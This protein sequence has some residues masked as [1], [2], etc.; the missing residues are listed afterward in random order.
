M[1]R[2]VTK[3]QLRNRSGGGGAVRVITDTSTALQRRI[4]AASRGMD[5]GHN[6]HSEN[7]A[8][9]HNAHETPWTTRRECALCAEYVTAKLDA[10]REN[11][12]RESE[13]IA[14]QRA[15]AHNA[16]T[17]NAPHSGDVPQRIGSKRRTTRNIVTPTRV[18]DATHNGLR[19]ASKASQRY[20][21]DT[22]TR[23]VSDT[24]ETSERHDVRRIRR[25][26]SP[27]IVR[28]IGGGID[29]TLTMA[30]LTFYRHALA[31]RNTHEG[32]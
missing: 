1:P 32:I 25:N 5:A 26:H 28:G 11:V 14:A 30:L 4:D 17:H 3:S 18:G 8:N 19:R 15:T 2:Q 9:A 20:A 10:Q 31:C 23:N 29:A 16:K 6:A 12:Q 13:T 21:H 27:L 7:V 24:V 22:V